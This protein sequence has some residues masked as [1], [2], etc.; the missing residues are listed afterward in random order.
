VNGVLSGAADFDAAFFGF[1]AHDA[2]I[3]DPQHRVF[4]ECAWEA[5]EDAG[6]DP[7]ENGEAVG[8]F[9]GSGTNT[10]RK[11]DIGVEVDTVTHLQLMVGSEKDFLATRVA[12]KLNLTGPAITLQTACSTSL[13]AVQ[14]AYESIRSGAC[15]MALAGGVS[16]MFPQERGYLFQPGM[17]LSPD[18]YCRAFDAKAAG[19]TIG[20]GAGVVLL[21]PLDAAIRDRDQIYAVIRGAAINND[22]AAKGGYTAPGVKGQTEVIRRAMKMAAF[23]PA[24]VRYVEAHGTGTEIGD[25]IEIAALAEAFSGSQAAPGSCTVSSLKA[26]IGHLDAAAGVANL[27]K[28]ALAVKNRVLPGTMHFERANPELNLE[29]TPFRIS[30]EHGKYTD[31]APMRAGV[32][33]FGIGGTNAHVCIEEWR[34]ESATSASNNGHHAPA[35]VTPQLFP[36]SAPTEKALSAQRERLADHLEA[37]PELSLEDVAFTLQTGRKLFPHRYFAVASDREQLIAEL[38]MPEMPKSQCNV[39]TAKDPDIFFLFPGQGAQYVNMGRGLY[40]SDAVFR[41]V[42]DRCAEI[43]QPL[44]HL[45]LRHILFPEPGNEEA[46]TAIL[47]QTR[48]TQPAL[49]SLEYALAMRLLASGVAPTAMLGHSLGEYVASTIA[50]VFKLEHFLEIVAERGRQVQSIQRGSMLAVSLPEEAVLRQ[51]PPELSLAAINA[52]KQT[53]V[54]GPTKAVEAF[55]AS[56]AKQRVACAPLVTSHAFHSSMLDPV[57]ETTAALMGRF[58]RSAPKIPYISSLTGTWI[59]DKDAMD[60]W[61]YAAHLRQ[62]VRFADGLRLLTEKGAGVIVEVGPG[63]TLLPLARSA[64]KGMKG[65]RLVSTTRRA[66]SLATDAEYWLQAMGQLWLAGVKLDWNSIHG[67]GRPHRVSLPTYPFERQFYWIDDTY[68]RSGSTGAASSGPLVKRDEIADWLYTRSWR[69]EPPP[70]N[71]P[72]EQ[73]AARWAIFAESSNQTMRGVAEALRKSAQVISITSGDAFA[74][75]SDD[76][77]QIDFDQPEQYKALLANWQQDG[78]WPD[79]LVYAVPRSGSADTPHAAYLRLFHLAQALQ[80]SGQTDALTLHV[81]T[82]RAYDVLGEGNCLPENTAASSLAG[83]LGL[84]LRGLKCQSIDFD[85]DAPAPGLVPMLV[86]E[87][88]SSSGDE[89][90]AYRGKTRWIPDWSVL[91]LGSSEAGRAKLRR[92]GTYILTGGVGGIGLILA[93]HLAR[94][95]GAHLVLV[96]RSAFPPPTE[97]EQ[98]AQNADVNAS[99]RAKI[100][101]LLRIRDAGGTID[102]QQADVQDSAMMREV[103]KAAA[104]KG[105]LAGIIHAAGVSDFTVI[106]AT[107][108]AAVERI[109]AAKA[110]GTRWIEEALTAYKLDF[111]LLCSSMSAIVPSVGV[112][113]YGAANAYLDGFASRHDNPQGTRVFAVN[114]DRWSETGMAYEA[115]ALTKGSAQPTPVVEFGIDN[116]EA[117]Q[118]FDQVLTSPVSQIAVST[119]DMKRWIESVRNQL[120]EKGDTRDSHASDGDV[121]LHPRPELSHEYAPPQDDAERAVVEIWQELLGIDRIGIHDDFF[122]LGGHSLLGAQFISRIRERFQVDIPLRIIFETPTPAA[123]ARLVSTKAS[124]PAH[125]GKDDVSRAVEREE[126]EI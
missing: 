57:V 82:D 64:T 94:T 13:V 31:A 44:I 73:H 89:L 4:L 8:V 117:A 116:A 20:K 108:P 34:L 37:H 86:R 41:D 43:L 70:L 91:P 19:T 60:P 9:A 69:S 7:M 104:K 75:T 103:V 110:E 51:L 111:V 74:R 95:I 92:D 39:S 84:E 76:S 115:A 100:Q 45:D 42:I 80:Q 36:L 119:R 81:L 83:V 10:Y 71:F 40:E 18:G 126:I 122:E 46:A 106:G 30:S 61:Y 38:R 53:I 29:N 120:K 32:S 112:S 77:C 56:L 90:V 14:M 55:A 97:W 49:F 25:S 107:E 109:F 24:T 72:D 96:G 28:A 5:F 2:S 12:Y 35:L 99:L 48:I 1:S 66:S 27:I 125:A 85:H 124:S 65:I 62:T 105:N 123:C 21:K 50:E 22:G 3:V 33:S 47:K 52:P 17:I 78:L 26:S 121:A 6:Y 79:H 54:S 16:I 67:D 63:E 102:V 88:T 118:V 87:L 101:A 98:L 68:G 15:T 58:P 11:Q 93:E 113:A 114:W 23:D 59:T